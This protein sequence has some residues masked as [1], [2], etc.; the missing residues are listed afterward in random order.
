MN[1]ASVVQARGRVV[2]SVE[3]TQ[4]VA[5]VIERFASSRVRCLAV[6]DDE[7][8]VG[9]VTIR[10][11]LGRVNERGGDA[12]GDEVR[13][14]MTRDVVTVTPSTSLEE[15]QELFLSNR[16]NHIPVIEDERPVAVITPSDILGELVRESE[17][18]NEYMRAYIAGTY[19]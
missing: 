6:L 16:F 15:V 3:A 1:V 17:K 19:Q 14:V 18:T 4:A 7:R 9:V 10:D 13:D 11:I 5:E 12:L 8:L 2:H